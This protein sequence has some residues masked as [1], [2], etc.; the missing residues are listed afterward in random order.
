MST[1]LKFSTRSRVALTRVEGDD[2]DVARAA[3]VSTKGE[4][5]EDEQDSKKVR[6]LINMLMRDRHGSP[7][8]QV[9]LQFL[10]SAPIFVWREHM[11]HRMASYNEMSGRYTQLPPE[12]YVPD[13]HRPLV[14]QGKP[15]A[16][17]F[18]EGS[19]AQVSEVRHRLEVSSHQSYA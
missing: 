9:G 2:L 10:T 3:W 19:P 17:T 12:F 14:Q 8:E 11:R 7:F 15:G 13:P 4:R 5:A 18:I 1:A 16:Y 6:G